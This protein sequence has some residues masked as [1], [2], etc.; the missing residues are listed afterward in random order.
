MP[1]SPIQTPLI[2][3]WSLPPNTSWGKAETP[4]A[5]HWDHWP[6]TVALH[7]IPNTLAPLI[8]KNLVVEALHRWN[9]ML[10]H[11]H[12]VTPL[13]LVECVWVRDPAPNSGSLQADVIIGWDGTPHPNHPYEAGRCRRYANA[14]GRL[15]Q[16]V[17]TIVPQ[18]AI[19]DRLSLHQ[20]SQR[21]LSTLTHEMGHALGLEH[22]SD[23]GA[24]M[25]PQG[26]RNRGP[27]A[28]DYQ[29][30]RRCLPALKKP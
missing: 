19:D 24:I 20:R 27:N 7:P 26:W 30:L 22:H 3:P 8:N 11:T 4:L 17:I 5:L 13:S 29:Q 18:A 23:P 16:A 28:N 1:L 10:P 25:H 9:G 14:Q 21:L 6:L 15:T 12:S 2:S